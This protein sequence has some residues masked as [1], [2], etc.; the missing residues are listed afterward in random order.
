MG[1][2]TKGKAA[3]KAAK[4][5]KVAKVVRKVETGR[6][7]FLGNVGKLNGGKMSGTEFRAAVIQGILSGHKGTAVHTAASTYNAIR[8]A[9]SA[10]VTVPLGRVAKAPAKAT[11]KGKAS[12]KSKA[13][14][15]A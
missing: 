1:K 6:K 2:S 15:K 13:T 5:A 8:K 11:T 14:A 3:P 7:I 10:A 12:T 9:E 4:V